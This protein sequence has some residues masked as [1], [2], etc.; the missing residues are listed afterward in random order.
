M[1]PTFR[2][3]ERSGYADVAEGFAG[4]AIAPDFLDDL[5]FDIPARLT[6]VDDIWLSGHLA[7]RGVPIGAEA[8]ANRFRTLMAVSNTDALHMVGEAGAGR[9]EAN[10]ACIDHMRAVYGVWGRERVAPG[11]ARPEV[12]GQRGVDGL[13]GGQQATDGID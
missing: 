6:L 7:R 9:L 13:A 4:V 5:A 10:R 11:A 3:V 8:G 2:T 1:N 12:S